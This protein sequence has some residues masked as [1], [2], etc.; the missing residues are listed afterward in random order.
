MNSVNIRYVLSRISRCCS[1]LISFGFSWEYPWRPISWPASRT[2]AISFGKDSNEWPG[3]NHVVLMPY[4]AKSFRRRSVPTV[5]AQTPVQRNL[6][7]L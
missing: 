1:R 7:S 4:L 3:I 5:A 6:I 2:A